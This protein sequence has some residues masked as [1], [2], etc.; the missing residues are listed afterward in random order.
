[1]YVNDAYRED[2]TFDLSASNGNSADWSYN[3][4][5]TDS[6]EITLGADG[7]LT[8]NM[9]QSEW[10]LSD[11]ELAGASITYVFQIEAENAGTSDAPYPYYPLLVTIDASANIDAYIGGGQAAVSFEEN[12][13]PTSQHPYITAQATYYQGS[14]R[15]TS[16][17][18]STGTVGPTYTYPTAHLNTV[19]ILVG[20]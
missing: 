5:E 8:V 10:G 1:M 11:E 17:L 6:A 14:T 12:S 9:D 7:R 18:G 16:V 3:G 20:G 15:L 13:D 19:G 4:T 2:A